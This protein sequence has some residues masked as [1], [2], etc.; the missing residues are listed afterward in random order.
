MARVARAYG[1]PFWD[2]LDADWVD[3]LAADM[4]LDDVERVDR[5]VAESDALRFAQ[6]V[7]LGVGAP[8]ELVA[9]GSALKREATRRRQDIAAD[10]IARIMR[11]TDKVLRI[12]RRR[13]RQVV[14]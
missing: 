13:R 11:Q 1:S 8:S 10:D 5:F 6:Y 7:G 9:I 2:V 12:E 4:A 3:V 14:N